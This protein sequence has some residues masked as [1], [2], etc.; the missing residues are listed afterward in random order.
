METLEV[1][2]TFFKI[3]IIAFGGGWSTVGIIKNAVVPHWVDEG[4][5]RSLIAIAQSTPGPIALNAATMV[6]WYHGG[7][8]TA[9]LATLSVVTFPVLMIVLTTLLA[10]RVSLNQQN[11]NN[12][13]KTGSLAMMLMTLWVLRPASADP[14]LLFFALAAFYIGAFTRINSIWAILG[15]GF[16]N[17]LLGPLIRSIWQR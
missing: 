16:L 8:L 1:A 10:N 6:G 2:W 15:A 14:L 4:T 7:I 11:L 5:F 9:L 17:A 12:A 3:G 13:L